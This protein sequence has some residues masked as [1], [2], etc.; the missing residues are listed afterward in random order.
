MLLVIW[1]SDRRDGR[2]DAI[3][4]MGSESGYLIKDKNYQKNLLRA[5]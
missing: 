3:V 5:L 4:R 1:H 2:N